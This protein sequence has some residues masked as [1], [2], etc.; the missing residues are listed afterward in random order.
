MSAPTTEHL[1]L[2]AV[3]PGN[4]RHL[5]VLRF[6][7]P[8]ARPKA[9]VQASLHAD[10]I[11]GMLVAHHLRAGLEAAAAAGRLRGEVVLVPFANPIGLTQHVLAEHLGRYALESASNFNRHFPDLAPTAAERLA[12]RLGD[13]PVANVATVR[14]ALA[15][16][17]AATTADDEVQALRRTLLGLALDADIVLDLHCDLEAVLHL[18]LGTPLWPDAADLAADLGAEATLLARVSGASR[19]TR[20][21]AD[22]GGRSPTPSR[23][24]RFPRHV[25]PPRSSSVG[26]RT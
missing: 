24:I 3:A 11:P 12:G 15:E 16:A 10:E 14:A 17:L 5:T 4:S 20:R 7:R 19:S 6:G 21:S 18:Y 2:P 9:Y 13:D 1:P 23:T 26:S 22:R 8:G 25:S